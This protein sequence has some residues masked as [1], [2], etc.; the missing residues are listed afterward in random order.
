MKKR[1]R[2]V[3][4]VQKAVIDALPMIREK[5]EKGYFVKEAAESCGV[6]YMDYWKYCPVAERER[7]SKAW[8][9]FRIGR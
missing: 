5:V 1:D 3:L 9:M 6:S 4:E 2:T 7:I 8:R